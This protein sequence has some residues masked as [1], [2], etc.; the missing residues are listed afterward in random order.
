MEIVFLGLIGVYVADCALAWSDLNW[1]LCT[2]WQCGEVLSIW[3]WVGFPVLVFLV[4]MGYLFSRCCVSDDQ[5]GD[6]SREPLMTAVSLLSCPDDLDDDYFVEGLEDSKLSQAPAA[7]EL[8]L[9]KQVAP[10]E[11]A[12]SPALDPTK[13]Y[14]F[15]VIASGGLAVHEKPDMDSETIAVLNPGTVFQSESRKGDWVQ[16]PKGWVLF[17]F[18]SKVFLQVQL[19]APSQQEIEHAKQAAAQLEEQKARIRKEVQEMTDLQQEQQAE[20]ETIELERSQLF[21]SVQ[22]VEHKIASLQQA[23]KLHQ[24]LEGKCANA[25][26]IRTSKFL[27]ESE[28]AS[29]DSIATMRDSIAKAVTNSGVLSMMDDDNNPHHVALRLHL[30]KVLIQSLKPFVQ[31]PR[32]I[33]QFE[34]LTVCQMWKYENS[35]EDNEAAEKRDIDALKE[36]LSQLSHQAQSQS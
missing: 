11:A 28:N 35:K 20:L 17:T 2:S 25:I 14:K 3:L 26:A 23:R 1:Q 33:L 34:A 18:K 9:A 21:V 15:T 5:S 24:S 8:T 7:M 30:G 36:R 29:E 32:N 27:L 16:G 12:S 4:Q 13:Q 22:E 31:L 10:P 6:A 19:E